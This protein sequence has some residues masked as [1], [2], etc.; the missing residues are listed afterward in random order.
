MTRPANSQIHLQDESPRHRG[1]SG[2]GIR[3][4]GD[5]RI[6]RAAGIFDILL[7]FSAK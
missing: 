7:N 6:P 4:K 3:E 1:T 2:D 5:R